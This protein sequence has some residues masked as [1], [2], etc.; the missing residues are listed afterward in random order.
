MVL[1]LSRLSITANSR[2]LRLI[3]LTR[4][5]NASLRSRGCSLDQRPSSKAAR[6]FLTARSTSLTSH[7]ATLASTLPVAG[8]CVSKVL[9]D[10]AGRNAPLMKAC[11]GSDRLLA[12][13]LYSS[14]VRNPAISLLRGDLGDGLLEHPHHLFQLPLV[15]LVQGLQRRPR[16][17]S[18][19]ADHLASMLDAL[20]EFA[21]LLEHPHERQHGRHDTSAILEIPFDGASLI[22]RGMLLRQEVGPAADPAARTPCEKF[23]RL[24][25]H[26]AGHLDMGIVTRQKMDAV[27][28]AGAFL[29][30]AEIA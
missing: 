16:R 14:V 8:L 4:R 30:G 25:I 15:V 7:A 19:Q 6:A 9:P 22:E 17:A 23:Q 3:S 28:V 10:L 27:D 11:V 29:D 5:I 24:I 12:I 18:L 1:P 13:A 26:P 21:A 2:A 20:N